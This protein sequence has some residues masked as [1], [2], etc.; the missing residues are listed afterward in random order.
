M[1]VRRYWWVRFPD[2]DFA[3]YVYKEMPKN[4]NRSKYGLRSIQR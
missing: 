2:E 1:V 3:K 4:G